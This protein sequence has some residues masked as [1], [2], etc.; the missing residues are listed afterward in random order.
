LPEKG[1]FWE[2]I[3][4]NWGVFSLRYPKTKGII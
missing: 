2:K 1:G 3:G 4:E